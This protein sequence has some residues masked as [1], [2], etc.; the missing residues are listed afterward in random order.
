MR[1]IVVPVNFTPNAANAARYATDIA[2]ALGM[3]VHLVNVLEMTAAS[4]KGLSA[5]IYEEL[6]NSCLELLQKLSAELTCRSSGRVQIATDLETGEIQHRLSEFCRPIQPFAVVCGSSE[7]SLDNMLKGSRTTNKIRKLP[8]PLLVVPGHTAFHTI[9]NVLIACD[10]EDIH[11]GIVNARPMLET[12]SNAFSP[13]FAAIHVLVDR[14]TSAE[15]LTT[16]FQSWKHIL[17]P[18][19][20]VITFIR[21][22]DVARGISEYLESHTADLLLVIPKKHGWLEG[23]KS[24]SP[25][26]ISKLVPILSLNRKK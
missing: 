25:E 24:R 9:R 20:P 19:D 16:E 14:K 6:L 8:Y 12:L 1:S 18:S 2:L 23:R 13:R 10:D 17:G 5:G 15:K 21:R 4:Y 7:R 3:D 11:T 22:P 26:I